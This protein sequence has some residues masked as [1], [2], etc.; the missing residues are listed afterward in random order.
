VHLLLLIFLSFLAYANAWPD[1]LV[2][3]DKPLLAD[4]RLAMLGLGDMAR[5]FSEGLWVAGGADAGIYRP[6]FLVWMTLESRLFGS[7][8][9]GHHL[10]NIAFHAGVTAC[11]YALVRQLQELWGLRGEQARWAAFLGAA[12]FAVHPV[13]AEVVN[14]IFNGSELFVGVLVLGGLAWF[15]KTRPGRPWLAWAGLHVV[16]LLA[17]LFRESAASLPGLA[18]ALMLLISHEPWTRRIRSCL[19]ALTLIL[20]LGLYF[21][22]RAQALA[23]E[24]LATGVAA[25]VEASP[26]A[27]G[28]DF[29]WA[30]FA[31]AVYLWF[32]S[33]RLLLWPYPLQIYYDNQHGHLLLKGGIQLLLL[34]FATWRYFA[35][36]RPALLAGLAFWYVALLPSSRI[37]AEAGSPA[38]L[39]DRF[40][41]LPSAGLSI[42]LGLGLVYVFRAKSARLRPPWGLRLATALVLAACC[43][44]T[45]ITWARNADWSNELRLF[46]TDYARMQQP[47]KIMY[48]LV[49]AHLASGGYARANELCRKHPGALS[50]RGNLALRCADALAAIGRV[51][52]A[53]QAYLE[54]AGRK[55]QGNST[56]WAN[57]R[58]GHFYAQTGRR[59][60][61]DERFRRAVAMEH[62][63][64]L[65]EYMEAG[66][67]KALYPHDPQRLQRA[68][69]HLERALELQP[70]FAPAREELG[71]LP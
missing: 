56:G 45:P 17:L 46:E 38:D 34:A 49:G 66:R 30:H 69:Q 52:E 5:L 36:G 60:E 31:R 33:L 57:Y 29:R 14:S 43:V 50:S 10:A 18:V 67:L 1:V 3:D 54:V 55:F 65:K 2:F 37:I 42:A 11:V 13:H 26:G 40:L 16:Y 8:Y 47:D 41:Y 64:F 62:L 68:R 20:P 28:L 24:G 7:W 27:A 19:P 4:G 23:G 21:Y 9:A 48:T 32:D 6:L 35:R 25:G 58:L 39:A 70:R 59:A 44:L 15:L 12:V 71:Q 51:A 22:L 63:E 61:A 53:E